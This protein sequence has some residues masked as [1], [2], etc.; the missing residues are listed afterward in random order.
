VPELPAD[1]DRLGAAAARVVEADAL[2]L[3]L[4]HLRRREA[5]QRGAA[6]LTYRE[7]A[8]KTGYS[9]SIIGA[10]LTGATL[11]PADRFDVVIRLLGASPAEQQALATARDRVEERGRAAQSRRAARSAAGGPAGRPMPRQLPP[12][13]FGFVG[14]SDTLAG[15]D[16]LLVAGSV[17]EVP[18]AAVTGTAGV[19]KTALALRWA[20]RVADRFEGCLYLDLG[21]YGPA[22]PMDPRDALGILT[23]GL[24]VA[25]PGDPR[26]GELA[27]RYRSALAGRRILV[28]LDNAGS[29]AQVRPLLPG[30]PS[31]AVLVT[32]R[33]MLVGL[34]ARDGARRFGLDLMPAAEAVKLLR[35]LLGQRLDPALAA[36]LVARCAGLPLAV[37]LA[38]ELVASRHTADWAGLLAELA[39]EQ[40]RLDLLSAAGDPYT[41]LREVFSWSYRALRPA[42]AEA[43]RLLG[44]VPGGDIGLGA[45][46][47]LTG[48]SPRRALRLAE[49]LVQAQLLRQVGRDRYALHELLR[50]YAREL[51]GRLDSPD[52]RRTALTRLF[53]H[54]AAERGP[55]AGAAVRPVTAAGT[56]VTVGLA[57]V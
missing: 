38:A 41:D 39:D 23:R 22:G 30:D 42:V 52:A 5:R 48:T 24:G 16:A 40:R 20:H 4:R 28:V 37:R 18:I 19:G 53:G 9:H 46:A 1:P 51:A 47:A 29:A 36:D 6:P 50:T 14:R 15:L 35:M 2:A 34:V 54:C 11:A 57:R 56:V 13:A 55:R 33:D 21:G 45:L 17:G 10:Y 32:S 12:E 7:L 49:V 43:F 31:C 26:L 44:L 27:A 3:L 25:E 8:A